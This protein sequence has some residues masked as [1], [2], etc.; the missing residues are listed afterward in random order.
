[1][2]RFFKVGFF[3]AVSFWGFAQNDQTGVVRGKVVDG[4]GTALP[5]TTVQLAWAD[6]SN[7]K[8]VVT[9]ADGQY[10]AGFLKPGVYV[11]TATLAGF[12]TQKI[13]EIVVS[14]G[15]TRTVNLALN[16]TTQTLEESLVVTLE[17]PLIERNT[18]EYPSVLND[19]QVDRLPVSSTATD[20]IAFTAGARSNQVWG[21][22]TEQANAYQLDG[23]GVNSPGF[24]GSF[25]L[26]NVRWIKE[27]QV[28]GLGAGAEYGN[29]QG[30]LINIVTRSGSN[31]LEGNLEFLYESESLNGSNLVPLEDGGEEDQF[32]E[33]N[34]DIAGPLIKDKL[35]YF[36]SLEQ[37]DTDTRI[38]DIANSTA[39]SIAFLADQEQRTERKALAKLTYQ[40][41][42]LDTFN[43]YVGWDDVQTDNRGLDSFTRIEATTDQDSPALLYNVSWERVLGT[44]HFL[45][46]KVTGY[47][48]DN[49][50]KPKNGNTPGVQILGGNRELG[51]NAPYT[52]LQGLTSNSLAI[53][54]DSLYTLGSTLHQVKMGVDYERG[55]WLEQRIRNGN[56]TWRPEEGDGPFD[57]NNPASWGFI[58]SD[59]GGNIRLDAETLNA[60]AYVQDYI[61]LTPQLDVSI[62]ARY[63]KWQGDVTPGFGGGSQFRAADDSAI[64]P[65]I[66]L[67]W[68]VDQE[69]KH[70]VKAH[71]GRF[72]QSIFALLFD[73]AQGTNAFQD[74]EYWDWDGN[75]VPDLDRVYTRD[76]LDDLF[77]FFD[78]DSVSQ[79]NG[80]V[81]DYE[82]PYVDQI[83]L[84]YEYAFSPEWKVGLTY[85][86]REN[87]NI[88]SL[89]DRNM[90]Q[91]YT[92]F[93]NVEVIDYRSGNPVL[94]ASG[95]PLV[96]ETVYLSNQDILDR[97]W[98]PGLTDAQVE[99]LS[100]NPDLVLTNAD[101]AER[102]F[103][104][105]Q[106]QLDRR[107]RVWDLGVSITHTDLE[108]NF[109]SV[110]GYDDPFGTG[111]GAFVN[112]N[113][114]INFYGNMPNYAE[115]DFKVRFSGDLPYGFRG[116]AFFRY[117][118]GDFYTPSYTIDRRNDDFIAEDGEY[119]NPRHFSAVSGQPIYLEGR[120]SR[121]Y[122]AFHRL[123]LHL[124]K[125]FNLNRL[126]WIIGLDAFNVYGA[127]AVTN[128]KSS[129]NG[130]D[131][132]DPTSL[133]G[134]TRSRQAPRVLRISTSLRW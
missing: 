74:L 5:G 106:L 69:T 64:D 121:E 50:N 82:Q 63:G 58:S 68:Q 20:L 105:F 98:A 71:W 38:V 35:Y 26:P 80:P 90:D 109:Y 27:F 101:D 70:V 92:A 131:A 53:K 117:D 60:A 36:F 32:A 48:G 119:F 123:D 87:K 61:T 85:V 72:H 25:L 52:R 76:D 93:H 16:T 34:F 127:D 84:G 24:G 12:E 47:D 133:F 59:W 57:F 88:L 29:F 122:D 108:G 43:L 104:Q 83:V 40:A 102:S 6:G 111:A 7:G 11:L 99:A 116:G 8:V 128:L 30:G 100:Y 55:T 15:Q 2:R 118:S 17:L 62:G 14:A 46:V 134:A 125:V 4:S 126:K 42:S 107:G 41:S 94:D 77:V 3:V 21:G 67:V 91:N 97:G 73:R 115:W 37:Q 44:N 18:T 129:V 103:D 114:R 39:S 79:E 28:K 130:Q 54:L 1:M 56:M 45:E 49:D 78:S 66:G 110:S 19:D 51:R 112:P 124:D 31:T 86:N 96:L 10:R 75:D 120:G 89:V 13:K 113:Q 132:S 9:D 33:L 95:Q 81:L 65:R 23:V 22:S